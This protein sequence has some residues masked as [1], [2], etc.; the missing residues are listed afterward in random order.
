[1]KKSIGTNVHPPRIKGPY[2]PANSKSLNMNISMILCKWYWD[3][4]DGYC[5]LNQ[6]IQKQCRKEPIWQLQMFDAKWREFKLERVDLTRNH[7]PLWQR[8]LMRMPCP[9]G[10]MQTCNASEHVV[11][12]A[13][14]TTYS[15]NEHRFAWFMITTILKG[16]QLLNES[17]SLWP[18]WIAETL[19]W[20]GLFKDLHYH[21]RFLQLRMPISSHSGCWVICCSWLLTLHLKTIIL[22]LKWVPSFLLSETTCSWTTS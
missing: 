9:R 10:R 4:W 3:A 20:S 6:Q 5:V 2:K 15:F 11:C 19:A 1:M 13:Q 21:V 16:W 8:M 12:W 18:I 14:P 22:W 7:C 17:C